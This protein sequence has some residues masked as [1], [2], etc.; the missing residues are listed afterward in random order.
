MASVIMADARRVPW[1]HAPKTFLFA[2]GVGLIGGLVSPAFQL[3][4]H[5]LQTV[6]IGPGGVL[7]AAL[8]LPKVARL[9]IPVGGAIL[10][11]L[12]AYGFSKRRKSQGMSDVMEACTLRKAETLSIRSTLMRAA[13]SLALIATGGSVGRE[14]PIVYMSAAFGARFARL[15]KFAGPRLGLYAGCGVA[16][17]MSAAYY[18]PLGAAIFAMEIVLGNFAIEIMAPVMVASVVSSICAQGI[19]GLVSEEWMRPPPLY[20]LEKFQKIH[21]AE[22]AVY[23]LLGVSAAFGAKLF[24][25]MMRQTEGVF[26]RVPLPAVVKL[27]IGG[28]IVGIIGVW[29]PHVWGNGYDAVNIVIKEMPAFSFVLLLFILKIVATSATVGSGGSGGIFTPTLFVGAALG[30]MV[31]TASQKLLPEGV[32]EQSSPY[33][34]VGMAAVL[35]ATTHAPIMAIFIL[36]EMTRETGMV[37]PMLV[38]AISATVVSRAIGVESVYFAPLRRRGIHIP[39]GIEETALTTTRVRDIMREKAAWI[40]ITATFD[41]I[42]GMVQKTRRDAIYVVDG[43][44]RLVGVIRLH[45]IKAYLAEPE[46]GAAVLATDLAIVVPHAFPDQTLAEVLPRFDDPDLDE[47]PVVHPMDGKLMGVVDRRDLLT[48]LSVEVLQSQQLRAKFVEHGG[49]QHYVEIQPGHAVSRIPVPKE[50]VGQTLAATDF[51]NRTGLTVLTV[52]RPENGRE[53]RIVPAPGTVLAEGDALIVMGPIEK[54]Q[55]LGG[56]V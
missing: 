15:G 37:V 40:R 44:L 5:L 35:A 18:A 8:A 4:S 20:V 28:L 42:V 52:I 41:M 53:V 50:M 11:A 51:R 23:I 43:D 32:V 12:L 6:F 14:G 9:F 3:G 56:S 54:I 24:V 13:S 36:F 25:W 16:A 48:A 19:A 55:G 10:A 45:D 33:A 38:A 27:P 39:E 7:D 46:L 26:A 1:A 21:P 29:L 22:Y 30:L 2:A 49:A 47:L 31:G 34:V 17:G